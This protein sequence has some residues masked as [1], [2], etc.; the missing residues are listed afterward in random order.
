LG[1][2][3]Y[4]I[5]DDNFRTVR[6]FTPRQ[7]VRDI[8]QN[9][10][11]V[12]VAH[13]YSPDAVKSLLK[14]RNEIEII[15][16]KRNINKYIHIDISD[17]INRS[18]D[19]SIIK[20]KIV[21]IG[22]M[23]PDVNSPTTEDI[24]FTPLNSQFVGKTHPDMYGVVVWA[25][26]IS[27]IL[28][29]SYF[30]QIPEWMSLLFT[31]LL[32]YFNMIIF[33]TLR[34]KY[35]NWYEPISILWTFAQIAIIFLAILWTFYFLGIELKNAGAFFAILICKQSYELWT[36]SLKPISLRFLKKKLS[37]LLQ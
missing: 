28:E 24:F 2:A 33:T 35:E 16:F 14:R 23:G 30:E 32:I 20:N 13:I 1:Y 27:M 15:N 17:I 4:I 12:A 29:G 18:F 7:S 31:I 6:V 3:N 22:Y 9:C 5:N 25:N 19:F 34:E 11:A 37:K 21:L 10:F 36:D 26:I 8:Y